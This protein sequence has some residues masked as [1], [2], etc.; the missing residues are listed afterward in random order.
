[1]TQDVPFCGHPTRPFPY[2]GMTSKK[3]RASATAQSVEY[4]LFMLKVNKAV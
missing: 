2:S 4:E 1:M 3:T